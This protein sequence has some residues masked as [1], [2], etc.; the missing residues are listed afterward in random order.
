MAFLVD[1][2]VLG[3][4][5]NQADSLFPVADRAIITLGMRGESLHITAQN[6]IEFRNAATRPKSLN[7]LGMTIPDVEKKSAEFEVLFPLLPD[8]ADIFL[9]WKSLL[10]AMGIIGKRVHDARLVAVCHVHKITH[11]LT[12]N[13][14]HFAALAS[15]GPGIIIVDPVTV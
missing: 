6:L 12:F 9:A 13:T 5:A 10:G 11:L 2:S 8:N 7:G 3:R 1:T 14:G 4:L 15:F